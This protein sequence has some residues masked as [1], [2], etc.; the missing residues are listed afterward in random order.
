[1]GYVMYTAHSKFS[2]KGTPNDDIAVFCMIAKKIDGGWR[3][4]GGSRSNGRSPEEP[5]PDFNVE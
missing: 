4:V 3:F 1:M 2:F 5:K